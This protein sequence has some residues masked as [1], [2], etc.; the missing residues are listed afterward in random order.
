MIA[1]NLK[2][3]RHSIPEQVTLVCIS[4]FHSEEAI[5]EAY[6]AGEKVF[7]ESKVQELIAKQEKLPKDIEWH[8]IGH[9]QTNKIKF[10]IPFVK[11]IHGVD[12]IKL[13][14]EIN[15]Q[16]AKNQRVIDCL[17]Q[18]H[19]ANE[20]TK[21]GFSEIELLDFLRSDARATLQFINIRGLM[22]MATFTDDEAQVRKEFNGLKLLFEKIKTEFPNQL[23]Q[24]NV[25]SMGMSDDYKL[26]IEEGSNMVR[27]GSR[28]FGNRTY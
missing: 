6:N 2:L 26:A 1:Q 24:F 19:I 10:L 11:L 12:T 13:L 20:D 15:N 16:A 3:L 14:I 8:F 23:Q 4:K 18:V 7:G 5:L 25:I 9:L 27:I 17:L 21:F 28:I 22:G